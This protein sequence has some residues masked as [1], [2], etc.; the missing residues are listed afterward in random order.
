MKCGRTSALL[1][2]PRFALSLRSIVSAGHIDAHR[3]MHAVRAT[4]R[5]VSSV[6]IP[7]SSSHNAA[8]CSWV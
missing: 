4:L 1:P 7:A 2:K 8:A 6:A 3:R 5:Q